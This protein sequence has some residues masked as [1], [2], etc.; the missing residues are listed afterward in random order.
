MK[1]PNPDSTNLEFM[2][3]FEHA[4]TAANE[5]CAFIKI[6]LNNSSPCEVILSLSYQYTCHSVTGYVV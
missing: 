6:D 3:T 1:P 5:L 4:N 2:H